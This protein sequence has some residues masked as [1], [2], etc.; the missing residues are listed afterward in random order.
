M[1]CINTYIHIHGQGEAC[2][3]KKIELCDLRSRKL[4]MYSLKGKVAI[5]RKGLSILTKM[6]QC[7]R[8]TQI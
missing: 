3:G 8:T 2:K 4:A 5:R 1:L 6:T 7:D